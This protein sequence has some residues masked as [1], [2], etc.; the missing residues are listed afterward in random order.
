MEML[1]GYRCWP[2]SPLF[3]MCSPCFGLQG[4]GDRLISPDAHS[5]GKK[6]QRIEREAEEAAEHFTAETH[7]VHFKTPFHLEFRVRRVGCEK[8]Q[9]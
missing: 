9:T 1:A 2:V 4:D 5:P 8:R 3:E 7:P 6:R